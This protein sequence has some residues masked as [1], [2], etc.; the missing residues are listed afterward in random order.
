MFEMNRPHAWIQYVLIT[1]VGIFSF[2]YVLSLTSADDLGATNE[3]KAG[4]YIYN[5]LPS[6]CE[7][8]NTEILDV[9]ESNIYIS[10]TNDDSFD[11]YKST[12]N[13]GDWT[14]QV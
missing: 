2:C 10:C 3:A 5:V 13:G 12:N 9:S 7:V 14:H 6:D 11:I 4:T 8:G 1:V